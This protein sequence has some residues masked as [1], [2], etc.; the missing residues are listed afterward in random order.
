MIDVLVI[1]I[2]CVLSLIVGYMIGYVHR[3]G[4]LEAMYFKGFEDGVEVGREQT[5]TEEVDRRSSKNIID[6]KV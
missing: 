6:I 2:Q 3:D 5:L 1:G 4:R